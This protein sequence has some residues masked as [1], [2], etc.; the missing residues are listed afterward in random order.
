MVN[1]IRI[2][3]IW[4]RKFTDPNLIISFSLFNNLPL[5]N[6]GAIQ[7]VILARWVYPQWTCR[8]YV[9]KTVSKK[10]IENL[11]N[12]GAQIYFVQGEPLK[13]FSKSMWRFLVASEPVRFMCRDVDSRVNM[14]EAWVIDQWC[15][16]GK[17]FHRMWDHPTMNRPMLAG[18]WG[19]S[20]SNNNKNKQ[21]KSMFNLSELY[22]KNECLKKGKPAIPG[23]EK[24]ILTWVNDP[25]SKTIK[26]STDE[27]FLFWKILPLIKNKTISFGFGDQTTIP[28]LK[29]IPYAVNL[30][31]LPLG[32]KLQFNNFRTRPEN[33]KSEFINVK[34]NPKYTPENIKKGKRIDLK[35]TNY[36][37]F[38]KLLG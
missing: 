5:L 21:Q 28:P 2:K 38:K 19:G 29:G 22:N 35:T 7:N 4:K 20:P 31:T 1:K 3:K 32:P 6:Q 27:L 37:F 30:K 13:G 12:E 10:V 8:F 24:M 16:S 36:S 18:L 33:W 34:K 23:I 14:K 17:Q 25:R 11:L 15:K 26:R 9:D